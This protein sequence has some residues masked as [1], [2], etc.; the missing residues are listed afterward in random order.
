[1]PMPSLQPLPSHRTHEV[2]NQPPPLENYNVFTADPCLQ[3]S[4]AAF[5]ADWARSRLEALGAIAG[6]A[7]TIALARQANR[8]IPTLVSHDRFGHRIDEVEFH[9]AWHDLMAIGAGA[10]VHSLPWNDRRPGAHVAR[11]GLAFLMNQAENGV[12]CPLA[13]TFAAVPVLWRH[14]EVA[15]PWERLA[16]S[17][18]YDRSPVSAAGKRAVLVG[19]AMTEKQGG[20]D[21]RANT[22]HAAAIGASGP[23]N[24]YRLTGHKWFCSAPMSDA[25]LTLAYVEDRL[26]CFLVPRWLPDGGHNAILL[27]RLKDKLGNR[28][29]ASAEIEYDGAV[30]YLVGEEG[31]GVPAIIERGHHTRLDAAVSSAAVMRLALTQAIHHAPHRRAFQ[32]RLIDQPMMLNLLADLCLES[33]ASTLLALRVAKAFD[34]AEGAGGQDR[35]DTRA[36]V[37]IVTALSKFWICQRA[38]AFTFECLQCLGG[39]GYIEDSVMPRLYREAPVNAIWEGC[40]NVMVLD[41][42]RTLEKEPGAR[43]A[44]LAELDLARGADADLDRAIDE[45]R[46][47]LP[48]AASNEGAARRLVGG[49][50]QALQA[51]LLFR[52]GDAAAASAFCRSRLGG[53]TAGYGMLAGDWPLD[54]IVARNW[55]AGSA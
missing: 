27:Q 8:N 28:S 23:G 22:T 21:L 53:R 42:L 39:N 20:S 47:A 16:R 5:G 33:E 36:F 15:E 52:H 48:T 43:E 19:M 17:A 38:P 50:A 12:C 34:D 51:A 7:E 30:A 18:D 2:T 6:S 46:Q 26:S 41:I 4:V 31:R 37:R 24:V 14:A 9:P 3:A 35:Q 29:N 49:A 1:M 55:P 54:E 10:E 13:M 11:A 44:L 45:L 32:R 25:F 40:G